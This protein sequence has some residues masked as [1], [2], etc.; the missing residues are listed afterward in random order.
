MLSEETALN[1]AVMESSKARDAFLQADGE[2]YWTMGSPG[3]GTEK[4]INAAQAKR[5]KLY[6]EHV[7]KQKVTDAARKAYHNVCE[8]SAIRM[9]EQRETIASI[10]QQVESL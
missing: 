6:F 2:Y 9:H 10:H 1:I 4:E 5:N 3:R 7:E 8:A